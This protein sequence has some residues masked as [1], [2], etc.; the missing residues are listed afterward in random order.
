MQKVE[1]EI[2]PDPDDGWDD[3]EEESPQADGDGWSD[4]DPELSEVPKLQ[5]NK[6]TSIINVAYKIFTLKDIE[7]Q[8]PKRVEAADDLLCLGNE[9]QVIAIMRHFKWNQNKINDAWFT[10]E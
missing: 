3:E 9:D 5:P 6:T 2:K 4:D 10:D 7:V 8:I 1:S